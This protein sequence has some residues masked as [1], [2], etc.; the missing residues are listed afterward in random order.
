M[1]GREEEWVEGQKP[2]FRFQWLTAVTDR[3]RF[4]SGR[5]S[6]SGLE[7]EG[8]E[9]AESAP[10]ERPR[11]ARKLMPRVL[12]AQLFTNNTRRTTLKRFKIF[13]P[14]SP[15]SS[16]KDHTSLVLIW[17]PI[18]LCAVGASNNGINLQ[19]SWGPRYDS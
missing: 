8:A 17:R 19:V 9:T 16:S 4:I 12:S 1:E 10:R 3:E 2:E 7:R 15:P 5:Q 14:Y 6:E 11:K 18:K 13:L